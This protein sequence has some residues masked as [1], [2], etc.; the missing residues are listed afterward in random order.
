M[1][2]PL[3]SRMVAALPDAVT[4]AFFLVLWVHP[5]VLGAGAL[6]TGLLIMLVEFIL[7]HAS[8]MIG[9]SLLGRTPGSRFPWTLLLGF[10]AMYLV[11]IAAYAWA[12]RQWWPLLAFAWLLLGKASLAFDRKLP[13]SDRAHRLQSGW[14]VGCLAYLLGAFAT[15]FIPLPRLGLSSG[16]VAQAELAGSGHWVSY[17]HTV[18][19]FGLFYFGVLALVK[20]TDFRLGPPPKPR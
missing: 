2:A 4:A 13:T 1:R 20:A 3:S 16:V 9:G 19:A 11:F 6:R 7:L 10:A 8:A 17:P 5:S 18:V 14:A 15:I 12:F